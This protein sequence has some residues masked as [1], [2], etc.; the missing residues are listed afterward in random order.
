VTSGNFKFN[1]G[2]ISGDIDYIFLRNHIASFN[3]GGN[4]EA[5][6]SVTGTVNLDARCSAGGYIPASKFTGTQTNTCALTYWPGNCPPGGTI[7]VVNVDLA[8][9]IS[10]NNTSCYNP[11]DT[12]IIT[13]TAQ[14]LDD[15]HVATNLVVNAPLPSGFTSVSTAG[16]GTYSNSTG[17]WRIG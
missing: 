11:G 14:N 17:I 12:R 2:T 1:S 4:I 3:G 9:T 15:N 8:A 13:L 10:V 7:P 5:S 6:S 16:D